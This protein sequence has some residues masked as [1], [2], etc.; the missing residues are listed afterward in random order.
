M[1][2]VDG[3]G[4]ITRAEYLGRVDRAADACG[5]DPRHPLVAAA[6]A[7]HEEVFRQMD[8]NA[9]GAVT[10]E[11]YRDWAGHEAFEE[12]CRPALGS[13]FDLADHDGDGHLTRD[14]FRPAGAVSFPTARSHATTAPRPCAGAGNPGRTR[15]GSPP[16]SGRPPRA[17]P[18]HA[19]LPDR[20]ED[21][22]RPH[23]GH[24]HTPRRSG[25]QVR[26]RARTPPARAVPGRPPG[27]LRTEPVFFEE[28]TDMIDHS[29]HR[30]VD[31][32]PKADR[33][34]LHALRPGR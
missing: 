18:D 32:F 34:R 17:E 24:C 1:L 33:D 10:Y 11:E 6:L 15:H 7:A 31:Q 3:D 19:A 2:D 29:W 28:L 23:P 20:R 13:L 22:R 9:D 21:L 27:T 5:R 30:T 12:S 26:A 14:E 4:V 16:R 25:P 8:A